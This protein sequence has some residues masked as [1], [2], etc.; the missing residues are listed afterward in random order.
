MID[1]LTPPLKQKKEIQG[2][3]ILTKRTGEMGFSPLFPGGNYVSV[4]EEEKIRRY[5]YKN[6]ENVKIYDSIYRYTC[7]WVQQGYNFPLPPPHINCPVKETHSEVIN[8]VLVL[9]SQGERCVKRR[10]HFG[11]PLP[12]KGSGMAQ[13]KMIPGVS[14]G[15]GNQTYHIPLKDNLSY[16]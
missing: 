13:E 15:A 5:I 2:A 11:V 1:P 16:R 4:G 14:F 12:E 8:L 10:T 9:D 6:K 3:F 7:I